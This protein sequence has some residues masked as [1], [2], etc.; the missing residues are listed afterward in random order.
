MRC[1]PHSLNAEVVDASKLD[2]RAFIY[3]YMVSGVALCALAAS[4][5]IFYNQSDIPE[6]W[7]EFAITTFP[8]LTSIVVITGILTFFYYLRRPTAGQSS[9]GR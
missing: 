2:E 5:G 8:A 6:E 7:R 1:E 4:M 9:P 3:S